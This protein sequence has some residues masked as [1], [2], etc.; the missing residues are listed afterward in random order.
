MVVSIVGVAVLPS[1]ASASP[2]GGVATGSATVFTVLT[3]SE[4]CTQIFPE[5]VDISIPQLTLTGPMSI[6]SA[7]A[8][9]AKLNPVGF[10]LGEA[11]PLTSLIG[12][13]P[14]C[15]LVPLGIAS[16]GALYPIT[17]SPG[18]IGPPVTG[19]C[20]YNL[21]ATVVAGHV[22]TVR[23][24]CLASVGGRPSSPVTITLAIPV[25]PIEEALLDT[26]SANSN[27]TYPV[28]GAFTAA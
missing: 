21:Q 1:A 19:T 6:G 2:G 7:T 22:A 3:C 10:E 18:A 13:K 8:L 24:Q 26:G 11:C 15:I 20:G 17:I 5:P 25:L 9:S 28:V 12:L 27:L 14:A 23:I 16:G 4:P